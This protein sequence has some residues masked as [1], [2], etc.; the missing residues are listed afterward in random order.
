[1]KGLAPV[2]RTIKYLESGRLILKDKI[3]IVSI[4]YNTFGDHHHGARDFV[5]W[6]LPQLQYKNPTVQVVTFKN[7]TPTPFI[8]CYYGDLI[9]SNQF[10]FDFSKYNFFQRMEKHYLSM[11][12]VKDM[13][14]FLSI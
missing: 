10:S 9:K 14:R 13:M 6:S 8:K 5:F 11:L 1:M 3:R 4:N 7:L 12:T 2:R